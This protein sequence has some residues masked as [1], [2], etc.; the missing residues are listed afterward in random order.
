MK[1]VDRMIR[2]GL[3]FMIALSLF[4]S[5]KIWSN[6]GRTNATLDSQSTEVS[7]NLKAAKDVFVPTQLIFHDQNGDYYHSTKE[8]LLTGV[9]KKVFAF[10][11]EHITAYQLKQGEDVFEQ[12]KNAL[13]LSLPDPLLL[14]Y[15]LDINGHVVDRTFERNAMFNR[16]VVDQEGKQLYLINDQTQTGYRVA[17]SGDFKELRGSL[18]GEDNRFVKVAYRPSHLAVKYFAEEALKLKKYSYILG[19][20][21]YTIFSQAF[22]DPSEEI[23][24]ND[25]DENSKD[26]N[27]VSDGG[28]S[29]TVRYSTGEVHFNGRFVPAETT[30]GEDGQIFSQTYAYVQKLGGSLGTIRYFGGNDNNVT[31]RNFVEGYPIFS[32][33][34]KGRIDVSRLNGNLQIDANQETIQVPIPSEEVVTLGNTADTLAV[35]EQKGLDLNRIQRL[36]VGYHWVVNEE[37]KQVVDLVPDW[38]VKIDDNWISRLDL[39]R[40]LDKGAGEH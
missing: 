20:Q 18:T 40:Q 38:Y 8:S 31:Y 10:K 39:I 15:F 13:E 29:L 12:T 23:T 1:V 21:S 32:G 16:L 19:T 3:M 11:W 34:T 5:F 7:Q 6:S 14:R 4:L 2:Y 24:S 26:V 35:F 17:L 33:H 37:T 30:S 36:Q 27:L 22:F 28:S 25:D 9:M